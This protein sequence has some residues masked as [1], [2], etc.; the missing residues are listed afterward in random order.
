MT[1]FTSV[2][3]ASVIAFIVLPACG[4]ATSKPVNAP[5]GAQGYVIQCKDA[6]DCYE[7]AGSLCP[8]GYRVLDAGS[9]REVN[10]LATGFSNA[11]ANLSGNQAP[12]TQYYVTKTEALIE[13]E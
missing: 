1:W 2:A 4:G 5:S 11:G 9:R 7:E 6:G 3:A 13:C 12:P 10:A 8:R